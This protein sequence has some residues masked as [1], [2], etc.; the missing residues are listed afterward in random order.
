MIEI[1]KKLGYIFKDN[2]LLHQALTHPSFYSNKKTIPINHFERLEFIGDRVLALI[3]GE[4]LYKEFPEAVEGDLARRLAWLVC[5][6]RL[7]AVANQ[8]SISENLKY[9]RATDNN[10]TQWATFLSDACEALIGAVYFD[11]GFNQAAKV[12]QKFWKP[13]LAQK[14][15]LT[16]DPK[17]ELQEYVQA[18]YKELPHYKIIQHVGP[19]HN[20]EITVECKVKDMVVTATASSRKMAE[21]ES[22]QAMLQILKNV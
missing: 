3:V 8:M 22:A 4:M 12:I 1:Q 19:A 20:P 15:M 7:A 5:R 18:N 10:S 14:A 17:T 2:E 9:A 11:G 6:E 16:K 21:S 13:L